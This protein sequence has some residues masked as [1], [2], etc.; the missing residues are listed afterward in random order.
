MKRDAEY[1][2]GQLL[3]K[4]LIQT[5]RTLDVC[6]AEPDSLIGRKAREV[7]LLQLTHVERLV[8]LCKS[9]SPAN[10]R[11]QKKFS[12]ELSHATFAA[13]KIL[14]SV[15]A[16]ELV[17]AFATSRKCAPCWACSGERTLLASRSAW[18]CR[19]C[20]RQQSIFIGTVLENSHVP[21]RAW[22][23]ATLVFSHH[24]DV[25]VSTLS[26][27]MEMDRQATLRRVLHAIRKLN[28][29]QPLCSYS[30][31]AQALAGTRLSL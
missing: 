6:A 29:L 13:L 28:I 21:L 30:E 9:G 16:L 3:N 24:P 18:R 19:T 4:L 14:Q 12:S 15:D 31:V 2:V 10:A 26:R 20:N 23:A 25:T 1:Q 8:R 5:Q 27:V 7:A 17:I 11:N 22:F